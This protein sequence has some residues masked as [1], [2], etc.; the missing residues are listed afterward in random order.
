MTGSITKDWSSVSHRDIPMLRLMGRTLSRQDS[1]S[2]LPAAPENSQRRHKHRLSYSLRRIRNKKRDT[3]KQVPSL[4]KELASLGVAQKEFELFTAAVLDDLEAK[5]ASLKKFKASYTTSY[6][7]RSYAAL[8]IFMLQMYSSRIESFR[9]ESVKSIESICAM[10][11]EGESTEK[12]NGCMETFHCGLTKMK[13]RMKHMIDVSDK[14]A[15]VEIFDTINILNK[16]SLEIDCES[17]SGSNMHSFVSLGNITVESPHLPDAHNLA[18]RKSSESSVAS[19]A[20]FG[21]TGEE[22]PVSNVKTLRSL[23]DHVCV[24]SKAYGTATC[25]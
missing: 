16:V 5:V 3:A 24:L 15:V 13:T 25:K 23:S 22:R 2:S 17:Q 6:H 21:S 9:S 1:N 18:A 20:S 11:E 12:L 7:D 14:Y 10:L 19:S 8:Q 4:P